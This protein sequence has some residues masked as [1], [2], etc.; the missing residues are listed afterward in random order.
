MA[1]VCY[2]CCAAQQM[3]RHN[4]EV[5]A[6]CYLISFTQFSVAD[7]DFFASW[8]PKNVSGLQALELRLKPE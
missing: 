6:Y 5:K 8:G 2:Q 1:K 3:A 4:Q 7:A